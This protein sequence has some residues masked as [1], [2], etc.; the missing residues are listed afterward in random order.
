M[1]TATENARECFF[2]I[3]RKFKLDFSVFLTEKS[4]SDYEDSLR[5]AE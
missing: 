5:G 1:L 2:L 4:R 3:V